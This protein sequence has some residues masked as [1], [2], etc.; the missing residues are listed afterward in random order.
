MPFFPRTSRP[1][2]APAPQPAALA[3]AAATVPVVPVA[4]P[5]ERRRHPRFAISPEFP[6]RAVLGFIGRDDAGEPMSKSPHGWHWKGRLL[7]CSEE[8]ARIRLGPDVRAIVGESC[9]LQLGVQSFDLTVPCHV[10]RIQEQPDGVVFG[11]HHDIADAAT[12]H[13]YRQ[14]VEVIALGATLRLRTRTPKPDASG[15]VVERY[16]SNRPSCLTVWRHPGDGT[17][18]AFEFIL[19][20]SLVRA[21][22]NQGLEYFSGDGEKARP[23]SAVRCLEIHRLFQWVV[24]NLPAALPGDVRAFLRSYA[25]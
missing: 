22:V 24:P 15:Y 18:A 14:L 21:A 9:D 12:L 19:K 11:L 20:D 8:G 2:S 16:A 23:A 1:P 6:L 17:V 7:D 25:G 5:V 10:T 3:A 4:P 13:D